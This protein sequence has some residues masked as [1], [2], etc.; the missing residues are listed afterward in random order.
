MFDIGWT[1]LLVVAVV[2]IVVVGP[3]DLPRMLRAFGRWVGKVKAVAADFQ[4]QFNE[5]VRQAELDDVRKEMESLTNIDPL[6][7]VKKEMEEIS[8]LDPLAGTD[9]SLG[10]PVT[11]PAP[12]PPSVDAD[13]YGG[14]SIPPPVAP[15]VP[16]AAAVTE[17]PPVPVNAP[18]NPLLR[19]PPKPA[20]ADPIPAKSVATGE[21]P[22][23][24]PLLHSTRSEP[25]PAAVGANEAKV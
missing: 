5:A 25:A 14:G 12:A 17:R 20:P 24:N 3:K 9:T 7:D 10:P 6:A 1:E 15:A 2:A 18:R 8:T 13:A 19:V 11:A 21:P 23:P 22:P 4:R 16:A